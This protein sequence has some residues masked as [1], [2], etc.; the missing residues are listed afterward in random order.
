MNRLSLA[1]VHYPVVDRD[2][3]IYTTAITNMDVHDI[4]RSAKTFGLDNYYLVT[5]I[6]AQQELAKTIAGFWTDGTGKLKNF[7]RSSAMELVSVNN[8]LDSVV[9]QEL[10][11]TGAMPFIIATSAKPSLEKTATYEEAQKLI[12]SHKSTLLVFGTG[13]GLAKT[14]L[15]RADVVLTPIYGVDD[16]NHLSVRSAVA[17]ILDR[18][19]SR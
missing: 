4:A 13:H 5:P 8:D 6:T 2:G 18:L 12:K 17:I 16:Y 15:D 1:L 11:L 3:N 14:V 10:L 9:E 19:R 7:D